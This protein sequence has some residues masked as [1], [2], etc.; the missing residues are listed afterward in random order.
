MIWSNFLMTWL[1][2]TVYWDS[3]LKSCN[4]FLLHVAIHFR[5]RSSKSSTYKLIWLMRID[6]QNCFENFCRNNMIISFNRK[7]IN[8]SL[9]K[10]SSSTSILWFKLTFKIYS[11]C[12]FHKWQQMMIFLN[13]ESIIKLISLNF[14]HCSIWRKSSI[15]RI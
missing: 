13:S 2:E 11:V 6:L 10:L 9:Q 7:N 1:N 14:L 12:W 5:F 15:W 4:V 3:L 8:K